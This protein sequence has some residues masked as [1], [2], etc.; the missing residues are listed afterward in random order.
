MGVTASPPQEAAFSLMQKAATLNDVFEGMD[1]DV[2]DHLHGLSL[3]ANANAHDHDDNDHDAHHDNHVKA[4]AALKEACGEIDTALASVKAGEE[5]AAV[6][7]L[8]SAK[9]MLE[10]VLGL[11]KS[12]AGH[13]SEESHEGHEEHE[14]THEKVKHALEHL[15]HAIA[16]LKKHKEGESEA[17]HEE[18]T[19][20]ALK[21]LALVKEEVEHARA[22]GLR[23]CATGEVEHGMK[24]LLKATLALMNSNSEG[25]SAGIQH[26]A[27]CLEHAV[28]DLKELSEE[29]HKFEQDTH[30]LEDLQHALGDL[31]H[32]AEDLKAHLEP[33]HNHTGEDM[34]CMR[35]DIKH[36]LSDLKCAF[37]DLHTAHA[38]SDL[39]CAQHDLE[40]LADHKLVKKKAHV[41]ECIAHDTIHGATLA[42]K[43][44]HLYKSWGAR[45]V[46]WS[47]K[48]KE[49]PKSAYRAKKVGFYINK[50]IGIIKDRCEKH[51][52]KAMK[53]KCYHKCHEEHEKCESTPE[54]KTLVLFAKNEKTC[55]VVRKE[56][57][58]K[59]KACDKKCKSL[60][61]EHKE[62]SPSHDH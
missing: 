61:H 58:T 55:L 36:A 48:L 14:H 30:A 8:E 44:K 39:H 57:K 6:P 43:S 13:D 19:S 62:A 20:C 31:K 21:D 3:V 34:E 25:V 60:K 27:K 26:A 53:K 22:G 9:G 17:E 12:E 54:C 52:E 11:E 16:D 18:H 49:N 5:E 24:D 35:K 56:C 41:A 28:K 40:H 4:M 59:C 50:T 23:A 37:D 7:K 47:G 51:H 29:E 15:T 45:L 42:V 1:K 10:K 38:L 2:R 46:K 32:A 33:G